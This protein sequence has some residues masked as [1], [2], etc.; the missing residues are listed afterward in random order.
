MGVV[1]K[2]MVCRDEVLGREMSVGFLIAKA[3]LGTLVCNIKDAEGD[4]VCIDISLVSFESI[5]TTRSSKNKQAGVMVSPEYFRLLFMN[6]T[7][8]LENLKKRKQKLK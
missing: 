2:S 3:R 8:C 5:P 6:V 4:V 7:P 1:I